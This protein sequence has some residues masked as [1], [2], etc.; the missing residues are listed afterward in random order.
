MGPLQG[1]PLGPAILA[2]QC[3]SPFGSAVRRKRP[4]CVQQRDTVM[5]VL[6]TTPRLEREL[7]RDKTLDIVLLMK[8]RERY[9]F[10]G[11]N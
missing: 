6:R 8:R 4:L 5:T 1:W 10:G 2:V 9:Q 3:F 7:Q 11:L